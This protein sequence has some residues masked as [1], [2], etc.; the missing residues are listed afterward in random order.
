MQSGGAVPRVERQLIILLHNAS[1]LVD[2]SRVEDLGR[3]HR[4]VEGVHAWLKLDFGRRDR[5]VRRVLRKHDINSR[6]ELH[7]LVGVSQSRNE[8][9]FNK[10]YVRDGAKGR[11][12]SFTS[13]VADCGVGVG[14][15]GAR[16]EVFWALI[17]LVRPLRFEESISVVPP[18]DTFSIELS[19]ANRREG[20]VACAPIHSLVMGARGAHMH[21]VAATHVLAADANAVAAMLVPVPDALVELSGVL[22]AVK[23]LGHLN[24]CVELAFPVLTHL[25]HIGCPLLVQ[26]FD[27]VACV[28]QHRTKRNHRSQQHAVVYS[29]QEDWA[30]FECI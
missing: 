8:G 14:P 30:A 20:A 5:E 27:L 12:V 16:L 4:Y 19:L 23:L 18:T 3:V 6:V 2:L 28:D 9:F 7:S 26:I 10:F 21:P 13:V 25:L 17:L 1:V 15:L 11:R 29:K 24:V 22:G